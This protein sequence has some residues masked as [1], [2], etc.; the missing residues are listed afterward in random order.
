MGN[1]YSYLRAFAL[2]AAVAS[3][4]GGAINFLIDPYDLFGATTYENLNTLKPASTERVRVVKPYQADRVNATTVIGGNSRPEMGLDP[5]SNCWMNSEKPVFNAAVPGATLRLQTLFAMHAARPSTKLMLHGLDFSDFV[6]ADIISSA[7][8]ETTQSRDPTQARLIVAGIAERDTG[9]FL[10]RTKDRMTALF[11]L[12]TVAD[13]VSTIFAQRNANSATRTKLGFNPARDYFDII[14]TEGQHVLFDHKNQSIRSTFSKPLIL[15]ELPGDP[16]SPFNA[17]QDL[18]SWS[19]RQNIR[20]ILFI[21]PY[22]VDYLNEINIAGHWN[23]L[24]TWKRRLVAIAELEGIELWDFNTLDEYSTETPPPPGN[25]VSALKWFW[26]PA[27]Y[28]AELGELMLSSMLQR[29]CVPPDT[30]AF[31]ARLDADS[32]TGHLNAL[33]TR[34]EAL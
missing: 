21:N 33:R 18:I 6:R 22:H 27:H 31:G 34:L 2:S 32:Q 13:S 12:T 8:N 17:L 9:H 15:D 10:Q 3:G 25:R 24:E 19:R 7:T 26:E 29:P 14:R 23:L 20:L 28:R 4:V 1:Y 11:S 5:E 30:A 16:S